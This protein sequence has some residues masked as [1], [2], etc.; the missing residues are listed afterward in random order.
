MGMSADD[1]RNVQ[2]SLG[3][4]TKV[5]ETF[6]DGS[7]KMTPLNGAFGGR[8]T[9]GPDGSLAVQVQYQLTGASG[10]ILANTSDNRVLTVQVDQQRSN[11][12]AGYVVFKVVDGVNALAGIA[13]LYVVA[14]SPTVANAK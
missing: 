1:L 8:G 2:R 4:Q 5:G 14:M 6:A 12:A 13:M 7:Q 10:A 11:F 9:T 3:L